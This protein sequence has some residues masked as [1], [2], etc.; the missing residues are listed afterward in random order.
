MMYNINPLPLLEVNLDDLDYY[1]L[2]KKYMLKQPLN[3]SFKERI[4]LR[5]VA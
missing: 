1:Q 2:Y 3:L 4:I 5:T